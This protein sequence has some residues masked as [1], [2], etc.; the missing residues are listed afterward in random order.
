MYIESED[1]PSVYKE[2][3]FTM[4]YCEYMQWEIVYITVDLEVA[5]RYLLAYVKECIHYK[6]LDLLIK[7]VNKCKHPLAKY[8][9][10]QGF[11]K[12]KIKQWNSISIEF[13]YL[14]VNKQTIRTKLIENSVLYCL[15][16]HALIV[17]NI[18]AIIQM[19]LF[20]FI[21]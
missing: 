10:R 1:M 19:M 6:W 4:R 3:K 16:S 5:C 12:D 21:Q 14:F 2:C 18:W 11:W 17:G 20:D 15:P 13:L 8:I 7:I 9:Q